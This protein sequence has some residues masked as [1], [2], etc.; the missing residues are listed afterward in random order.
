MLSLSCN[1][2]ARRSAWTCLSCSLPRTPQALMAMSSHPLAVH[3]HQRHQRKHS[4]SKTPSSPSDDSRAITTPSEAPTAKAKPV[5]KEGTER[6]SS[7]RLGRRKYKDVTQEA[8]GR[9]KTGLQQNLPSVPPTPHLP[10]VGES[11]PK[12]SVLPCRPTD[13]RSRCS[14][15]IVLFDP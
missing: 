5:T 14:R 4:S 10:P 6:R 9:S 11:I 3:S 2:A 8:S 15:S 12:I 1:E 13:L 7:T